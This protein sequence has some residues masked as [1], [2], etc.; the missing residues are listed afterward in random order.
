LR[1]LSEREEEDLGTFLE[2]KRAHEVK[3]LEEKQLL[4]VQASLKSILGG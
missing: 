2:E 4:S 1:E 3:G